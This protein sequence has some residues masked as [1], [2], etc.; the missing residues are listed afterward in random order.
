MTRSPDSGLRPVVSVS[1]KICLVMFEAG[2][3][4]APGW[5]ERSVILAPVVDGVLGQFDGQI[6]A[7]HD[8]LAAQARIGFETPGAV[9]QVFLGLFQL[10][11]T[12]EAL[13][14]DDVAGG[15]GTA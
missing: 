10:V 5:A 1:R 6:G 3:W 13:A 11:E 9:E 4:Q 7:R 12:V 15:A 8:G 2:R 14:H